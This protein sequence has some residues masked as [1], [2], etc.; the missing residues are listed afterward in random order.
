MRIGDY[1]A[2]RAASS[3]L[4]GSFTLTKVRPTQHCNRIYP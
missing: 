3:A 2:I 4:S 1:A